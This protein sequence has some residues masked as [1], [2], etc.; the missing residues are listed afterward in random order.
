MSS[1]NKQ[2]L[3]LPVKYVIALGVSAVASLIFLTVACLIVYKTDDPGSFEKIGAYAA[4][5]LSVFISGIIA[6]RITGG[7]A[8]S[9]LIIGAVMAVTL[10]LLSLFGFGIEM[11]FGVWLLVHLL[12]PAVAFLGGLAGQKR[13]RRENVRKKYKRLAR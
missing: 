10:M 7:G 5:G 3:S 4:L 6:A 2:S 12:I 11:N 9:G 1:R 13:E 8:M